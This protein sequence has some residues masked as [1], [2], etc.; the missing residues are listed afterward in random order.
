[1]TFYDL[2]LEGLKRHGKAHMRRILASGECHLQVAA[3]NQVLRVP[4]SSCGRLNTMQ[5]A[6]RRAGG[7]RGVID[8]DGGSLPP[9]Q[10]YH[11]WDRPPDMY[12][13]V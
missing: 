10:H 12:C 2:F 6:R 4:C 1:L 5:V 9:Y 8:P 13:Y 11:T 7:R 3:R